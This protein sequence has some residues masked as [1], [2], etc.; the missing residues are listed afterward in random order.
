MQAKRQYRWVVWIIN[1]AL[2]IHCNPRVPLHANKLV[3]EDWTKRDHRRL[4][5]IYGIW[6]SFCKSFARPF[7]VN[8]L[9]FASSCFSWDKYHLFLI[10]NNEKWLTMK[11]IFW[12]LYHHSKCFKCLGSANSLQPKGSCWCQSVGVKGLNA[13]RWQSVTEDICNLIELLYPG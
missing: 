13:N 5:R 12:K 11:K 4:Q 7:E 8:Q 1:W 2:Q 10:S 3:S 6:Y 9:P